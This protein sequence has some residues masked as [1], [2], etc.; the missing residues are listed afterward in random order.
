MA[1]QWHRS[2]SYESAMDSDFCDGTEKLC[3]VTS[4]CHG[5][6]AESKSVRILPE[7]DFWKA[8]SRKILLEFFDLTYKVKCSRNGKDVIL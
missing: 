3:P 5:L 8:T 7:T 2:N 6:K 4:V 1:V